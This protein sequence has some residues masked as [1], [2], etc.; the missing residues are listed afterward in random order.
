MFGI[1]KDAEPVG[2]LTVSAKGTACAPGVIVVMGD[3]DDEAK[4]QVAPCGIVLCKHES[5][6]GCPGAPVPSFNTSEYVADPPGEMV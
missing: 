4:E 2:T 3:P 5:V 1:C 6:I